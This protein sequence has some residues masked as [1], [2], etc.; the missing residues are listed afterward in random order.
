MA[1]T[2]S[3]HEPPLIHAWASCQLNCAMALVP[4]E[5]PLYMRLPQGY[6]CKGIT[7]GTYVHKFIRIIYGQKQAGLV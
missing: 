6:R 2:Q 7:K 3:L 4:A 1:N 5:K